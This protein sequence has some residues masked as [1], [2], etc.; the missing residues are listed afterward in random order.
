MEQLPLEDPDV[1]LQQ[2]QARV[3]NQLHSERS[4]APKRTGPP[5]H[6]LQVGHLVY[7]PY[8]HDKTQPRNRYLYSRLYSKAVVFC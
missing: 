1:I 3:R 4:K 8:D 2:H 6:Q 5:N 7:L